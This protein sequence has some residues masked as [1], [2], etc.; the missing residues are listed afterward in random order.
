MRPTE[1]TGDELVEVL[2]APV[3]PPF[4]AGVAVVSVPPTGVEADRLA[5][6]ARRLATLPCVVVGVGDWSSGAS[7][8]VD[9]VVDS[10]DDA[11]PVLTGVARAPLAAAAL[12]QLLRTGGDRDVAAGLVAESALFS[13]LQG[14]PEHSRWRAATPRRPADDTGDRVRFAR[15]GS[16]LEVHLQRPSRRNAL[17]VAMRD[18]LLAAFAVAEA[19]PDLQV[20][21]SGDGP[22]FCSGGDL[23]EFGTAPDAATAHSVRLR[24]SIGA[25]LDRIS[26]RVSVRVHGACAGSGVELAAFA[27]RVVAHPDAT[28]ELP[29]LGLGLI[30]GAGGTVSLPD[31]MGRHRTAWLALT[32]LAVDSATARSWGLVDE[33]DLF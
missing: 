14:G 26:A 6:A 17:D 4:A 23:D 15:R 19:D 11:E 31:R 33:I 8:L 2:S 13:A 18:E 28:F 20:Q 9:V 7:S 25:V 24:R 5:A 16:T 30:P 12:A 21:W 10:T 3:E 27:G 29:E 22:S 1:W 32:G